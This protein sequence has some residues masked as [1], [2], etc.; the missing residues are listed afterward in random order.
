MTTSIMRMQVM[1]RKSMVPCDFV[2]R[3]IGRQWIGLRFVQD[4]ARDFGLSTSILSIMSGQQ[5]RNQ[6]PMDASRR[7]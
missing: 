3:R 2:M 6:D 4:W 1:M 7:N 5:D